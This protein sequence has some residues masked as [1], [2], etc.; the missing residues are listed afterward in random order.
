MQFSRHDRHP[1]FVSATILKDTV[2]QSSQHASV[3]FVHLAPSVGA[4][5]VSYTVGDDLFDAATS[6][7]FPMSTNFQAV[8]ANR[9]AVDVAFLETHKSYKRPVVQ[10]TNAQVY[11]VV[12][13][14]DPKD[15]SFEI[16]VLRDLVSQ[17]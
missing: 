14:G 8:M 12:A 15:S 2:F 1:Q 11:T 5:S 9:Y 16:V 6:F 3:R 10:F 17:R 13:C 7:K 4:I